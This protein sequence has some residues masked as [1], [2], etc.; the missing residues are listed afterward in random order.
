MT[1]SFSNAKQYDDSY[2]YLINY[3][4][5]N[6]FIVFNF[7]NS[8][9]IEDFVYTDTDLYSSYI[10]KSFY[11]RL[12]VYKSLAKS[13][14]ELEFSPELLMS[15]LYLNIFFFIKFKSSFK[16]NVAPNEP[17]PNKL[18]KPPLTT[19]KLSNE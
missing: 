2:R 13:T 3:S 19:D 14:F 16:Y 1:N 11:S 6:S 7:K 4:H 5:K 12:N 8:L 18:D 9:I 17:L 15:K 10:N